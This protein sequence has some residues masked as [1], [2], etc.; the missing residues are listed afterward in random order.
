MHHENLEALAR[1]KLARVHIGL[2]P[3]NLYP[4][5]GNLFLEMYNKSKR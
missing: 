3:K 1:K 4:Q 2:S 5:I